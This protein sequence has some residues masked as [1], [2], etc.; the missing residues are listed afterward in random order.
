LDANDRVIN[1][2]PDSITDGMNVE[3]SNSQETNSAA[4]A[5]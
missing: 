5:K 1:N 2:P 3:I 4:S